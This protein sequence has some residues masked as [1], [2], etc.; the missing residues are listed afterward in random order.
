MNKIGC[1]L[2]FPLLELYEIYPFKTG[3]SMAK[4]GGSLPSVDLPFLIVLA[5]AMGINRLGR[6]TY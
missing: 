6:E 4:E 2:I 3:I 5:A 1:L